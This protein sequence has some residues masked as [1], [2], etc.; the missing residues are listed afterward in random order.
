METLNETPIG[1]VPF[2][3]VNTPTKEGLI[4]IKIR[5]TYKG[6]RK[7]IPVIH[8]N[9]PLHLSPEEGKFILETDIKMMKGKRREIK[10]T[11][12]DKVNSIETAVKSIQG[13]FAFDKISSVKNLK[14]FLDLFKS[15][16]EQ[17]KTS[18]K[19][20]TYRSYS[21]SYS[22][23]NRFRGGDK[24]KTGKELKPSN[25]TPTILH[26]FEQYLKDSQCN[27]TTIGIYMRVIRLVFN[28]ACLKNPR[29]I[30]PFARNKNDTERYRIKKGS[31]H[32]S[33]ALTA[34]QLEA[35]RSIPLP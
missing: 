1:I 22:A 35:F 15:H 31:G 34:N 28:V 3:C 23:F 5:L 18:G 14:G 17:F 25:L 24:E 21:A 27:K 20:G 10:K 29:L 6:E 4:P 8:N 32:K 12:N 30:S 2:L 33:I 7:Y 16:I 11:I 9:K 26:D 19:L 13:E